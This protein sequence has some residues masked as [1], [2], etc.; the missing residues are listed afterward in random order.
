MI[1]RGRPVWAFKTDARRDVDEYSPPWCD[2]ASFF[3]SRVDC[4]RTYLLAIDQESNS[5]EEWTVGQWRN[6]VYQVADRLTAQHGVKA[7]DN[8]ATLA[9]N[10]AEALA[11]AF[12]VWLVGACLVPLD[13]HEKDDRHEDI[14]QGSGARWIGVGSGTEL[15]SRAREHK[16]AETIFVSDLLSAQHREYLVPPLDKTKPPLD[17][18]ALRI[19]TSGTSGEPKS[20]VLSMRSILLNCASMQEAFGWTATTRVLT[21]LPINHVN[22]LLINCFLPWFAGGS[23]VLLDKFRSSSFWSVASNTLATSSS[24]VPTVLE[25]LLAHEFESRPETFLEEVISGSGPL[26]P[27]T[28]SAFEQ[29]FGMPVRQIYGLSETTAVL[30]VTPPRAAGHLEPEFRKSVGTVVPHAQVKVVD[31]NGRICDEGESGEIVARGGMLMAGYA[32]NDTA[33]IAAFKG[34][35]FHTGDRGHWQRGPDTKVWFFVDG[36]IRETILRGGLTIAP[37][38]IDAVVES[39]PR[40]RRA[41][42]IPFANRWYGEE[43]AVFVVANGHLEGTELLDWCAERLD[44][45]MC[46]KVVIFGNEMPLT[47]TGKPRRGLLAEQLSQQLTV[48]WDS[49]FRYPATHSAS[50][51]SSQSKPAESSE[52]NNDGFRD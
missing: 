47:S 41:A 29:R 52:T 40:V 31:S 4:D 51:S 28:A 16:S 35:W 11:L 5:R 32:D 49:A 13:A 37:H 2:F 48:Y 45:Q 30:T 17:A 27:E 42:A 46:P 7:G 34:G 25:F 19:Y 39:H 43:I 23:T 8:V 1:D 21:V 14:L 38:T 10:S 22:G 24:L 12:A 18:P 15:I 6:A 50:E 3:S 33:N 26:R 20:V 36:R 9:G 44:R